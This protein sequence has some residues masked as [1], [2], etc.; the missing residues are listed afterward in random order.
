MRENIELYTRIGYLETH[1]VEEKG[2]RRV[3]MTKQLG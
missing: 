2:L 1:R 3:Y